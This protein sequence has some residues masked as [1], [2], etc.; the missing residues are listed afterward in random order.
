MHTSSYVI[1]TT[2]FGHDHPLHIA[3]AICHFI[4]M[5]LIIEFILYHDAEP[6]TLPLLLQFVHVLTM[7]PRQEL[8]AI[9]IVA[10][11]HPHIKPTLANCKIHA[12]LSVQIKTATEND[13][14]HAVYVKNFE[15]KIYTGN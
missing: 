9:S 4:G 1:L 12:I 2:N 3:N 11:I 14:L 13:M 10:I 7:H 5:V 15:S 8:R 6:N